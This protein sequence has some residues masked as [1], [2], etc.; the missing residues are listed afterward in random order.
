VQ[1]DGSVRVTGSVHINNANYSI[2][3]GIKK[4]GLISIAYES[5]VLKSNKSKFVI[6]DAKSNGTA[7][8]IYGPYAFKD[9]DIIPNLIAAIQ[10]NVN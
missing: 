4:K 1:A 10:E 6:G 5:G 8:G 7:A 2:Y 9:E 3:T